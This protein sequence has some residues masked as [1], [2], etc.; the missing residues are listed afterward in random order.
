MLAAGS[1][2]FAADAQAQDRRTMVIERYNEA[3]ELAGARNFD[4]AIEL[5]EE[6][7]DLSEG[8]AEL[9]DMVARATNLLPR[10]FMS[11]ASVAFQQFQQQQNLENINRAITRFEEALTAGEKYNSEEVVTQSRGSLPQLLYMKSIVQFR[12]EDYDSAIATLDEAIRLNANYAL[13]YYQKGVVIKAKDRN[14]IDEYTQWY[15]R[16]ITIG[17]QFNDEQT[18]QRAKNAM[19][20]ELIYQGVQ[21]K[22]NRQFTRAIDLL[23][24]VANYDDASANANYRLA[25]VQNLRQNWDPAIRYANRALELESG[26]VVDRAKIYFELGVAYQGKGDVARACEAYT[27]AAHGQ[28]REAAEHE[29]E[30][31]LKCNENAN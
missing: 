9:T 11:R 12:A 30:F 8:E 18:V 7:I 24:R 13:A 25:E 21:A 20:D 14:N 26:S 29:M 16:A 15:D 31:V 1:L 28:F 23:E 22:D 4:E 27:S 17:E 3:Q 10:V 19:R 2:F 5:L 6:V